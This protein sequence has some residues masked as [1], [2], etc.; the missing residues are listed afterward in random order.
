MRRSVIT[1]SASS[2][3][4]PRSF[5]ALSTTFQAVVSFNFLSEEN[6][7]IKR[8]Y[9]NA[10]MLHAACNMI[11]FAVPTV[12]MASSECTN[13]TRVF[14]VTQMMDPDFRFDHKL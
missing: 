14:L 6:V 7:L 13:T 9:L 1:W 11:S 4:I 10:H 5:I 2:K 8:K 12:F 3:A